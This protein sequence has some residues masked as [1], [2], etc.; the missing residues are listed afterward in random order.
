MEQFLKRTWAEIDLDAVKHNFLKIRE[1]IN[2]KSKIMC[3]V[4]ADA[5]G[6]GAEFLSKEYQTLGADWFSVSNI[7]E[8]M[9][10]RDC[11]IT[12]PILI[13]GYTPVTEAPKLAQFSIS[14][15]VLSEEYAEELSKVAVQNEITV[16]V[17]VKLDSGMARIG[18]VCHDEML[19]DQTT[20]SLEKIYHKKGLELEGLFTHFA[21]SDEGKD[22]EIATKKQYQNFMRVVNRFQEKG[23]KIPLCHC[24]NSGAI[25]DYPEM[26]LD[27]VRAG[28]ILYG[29][30]PSIKTRNQL[31]FKPVMQLK[32][33]ISQLKTV[34]GHTPV[35][36]GG[37]FVTTRQ[38]KIASVP[39]GYADGYFRS[40]SNRSEM[41]VRGK[42]VPVIGRVCMDQLMLD[43]TDVSQVEEGDVVT[44]FGKD[45]SE[46]I[47]ASDLA[48]L[49]DT[50]SYEIICLLGKRVPRVYLKDG[51]TVG[52]LNYIYHRDA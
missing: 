27:M 33:V 3:V 18:L 49:A 32:T 46:E 7:D 37:T 4:K 44:V 50:I 10:L 19:C 25:L 52:Q 29:L 47:S 6:H 26:D 38:T 22:G 51:K 34:K 30:L 21:V 28:I 39:I 35:S 8:A 31:D 45:G 48:K 20:R 1:S 2:P 43:V 5:Y 12:K 16:K 9:Q 41:L 40:F 15:A 14:Q 11:G 42:R 23:Y 36:Y 17:H 24:C 13:L